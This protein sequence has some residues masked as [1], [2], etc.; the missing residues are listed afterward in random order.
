MGCS[1]PRHKKIKRHEESA[2]AQSKAHLLR[3]GVTI[4]RACKLRWRAL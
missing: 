2:R 1:G 4:R 3:T